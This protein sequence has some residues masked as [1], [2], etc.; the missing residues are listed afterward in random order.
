[1]LQLSQQAED[2]FLNP[3]NAGAL[4]EA[5]AVGEAGSLAAGDLIRLMLNV[6]PARGTIEKAR[7]QA[8]GCGSAIAVASALT[9]LVIGR[10]VETAQ[11]LTPAEIA[12]VLGGLPPEREYCLALGAKAL[13]AALRTWHGLS[14]APQPPRPARPLHTIVVRHRPVTAGDRPAAEHRRADAVSLA[15]PRSSEE[16][17]AVITGIIEEMRPVFRADG[18]DVEFVAFDG[19]A[20]QVRLSGTCAGCQIASLTL[21]GLRRRICDRLCRPIR[22]IPVSHA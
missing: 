9:E 12:D 20:L 8:F 16:E 14:M 19:K 4:A 21:G 2:H 11:H 5:N 10:S 13:A 15:V 3:R 17:L 18:G 22:V 6:D 1:M 7:F